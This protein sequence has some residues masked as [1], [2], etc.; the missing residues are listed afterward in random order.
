MLLAAAIVFACGVDGGSREPDAAG[1]PLS[2]AL[3]EAPA[4]SL[5]AASTAEPMT[6]E[7]TATNPESSEQIPPM[8]RLEDLL[9][10]P[11]SMMQAEGGVERLKPTKPDEAQST[12]DE[13]EDPEGLRIE[14]KTQS[15]RATTR[16]S[17]SRD[18][19]DAGV[20]VGVS[21]TI[22]LRGGVRLEEE[23]GREPEDPVPTVGIEKR[24]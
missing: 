8:P 22:R 3:A 18:R 9:R 14:L 6:P 1:P 17:S 16:P 13:E 12:D 23:S 5:P 7:P 4:A 24:F 20:S 11:A 10:L 2:Q 21:E 19:T 15:D